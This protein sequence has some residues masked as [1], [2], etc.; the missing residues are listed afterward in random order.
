MKLQ[1]IK[2]VQ[3]IL[4]DDEIMAFKHCLEYVRHRLVIHHS[5]GAESVGKIDYVEGLLQELER[6]VKC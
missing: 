6:Q 4:E 3:L 2:Q 5:K 1:E